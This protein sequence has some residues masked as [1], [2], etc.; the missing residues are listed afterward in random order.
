MR[1]GFGVMMSAQPGGVRFP[2]REPPGPEPVQA[3]GGM[4]SPRARGRARSRVVSRLQEAR[5]A[6]SDAA[7][8]AQDLRRRHQHSRIRPGRAPASHARQHRRHP[9]SCPAGTGPA[10][11]GCQR[12]RVHRAQHHPASSTDMQ[13]AGV[14]GTAAVAAFRSTAACSSS[15]AAQLDMSH[16]R[17]RA[18]SRTTPTMRSSCWPSELPAAAPR[19]AGDPASRATPP[20]A[21]R[22]GRAA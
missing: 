21:A 15:T 1:S 22:P 2:A 18:S 9:V 19:R 7:V 10:T 12:R 17:G 6:I 20:C 8:P 3:R 4:A 14:A 13:S 5:M 11:H 16:A